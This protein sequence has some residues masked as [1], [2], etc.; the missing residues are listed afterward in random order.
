MLVLICTCYRQAQAVQEDDLESFHA[1]DDLEGFDEFDDIDIIDI[2][3]RPI[4]V[5]QRE[6][7]LSETSKTKKYRLLTNP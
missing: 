7:P 3:Q 4:N 6:R 1:V 5:A 2:E